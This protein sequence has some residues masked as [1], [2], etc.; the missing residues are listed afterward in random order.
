M[1]MD[2]LREANWFSNDRPGDHETA[3]SAAAWYA[4]KAR[5]HEGL[6]GQPGHDSARECALASWAYERSRVLLR[7]S[8]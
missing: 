6:A 8:T 1:T 3:E 7:F 4:A 2:L 5:V